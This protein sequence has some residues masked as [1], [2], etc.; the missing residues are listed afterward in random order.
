MRRKPPSRDDPP[1]QRPRGRQPPPRGPY[2][3]GEIAA[4][5]ALRFRP[6]CTRCGRQGDY[7]V[8]RLIDRH[9][10]DKPLRE[11]LTAASADCPR[12]GTPSIY[13]RCDILGEIVPREADP[14]VW[15]MPKG[16]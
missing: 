11:L 6:R 8:G 13:D 2:T 9:G 14:L 10:P 7:S 3:L 12:Y 4:H 1:P 16:S 5:G 15:D